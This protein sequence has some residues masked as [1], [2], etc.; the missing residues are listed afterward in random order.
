MDGRRKQDQSKASTTSDKK[1]GRS[2]FSLQSLLIDAAGNDQG[3][4][5]SKAG[6]LSRD[7]KLDMP[8]HCVLRDPALH[9]RLIQFQAG[10]KTSQRKIVS[11]SKQTVLSSKVPKKKKKCSF[12]G[13]LQDL[14]RVDLLA[15]KRVAEQSRETQTML[16]VM[17]AS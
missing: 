3:R 12:S 8:T 5:T 16:I 4:S 15:E 9:P 6:G 14:P 13:R 7:E 10:L 11:P 17:R 1:A 2:T